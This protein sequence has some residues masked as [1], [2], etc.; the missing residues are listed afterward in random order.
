MALVGLA[1]VGS[2]QGWLQHAGDP[3]H[4][5]ISKN[6]VQSL[7]RVLWS[8]KVDLAPVYSGS[9]LLMHYGS[10]LISLN[11][12]V[13]IPVKT[14]PSDGFKVEGRRAGTGDL[15]W[16][17][18][19]DYS[20]PPHGW[21]PTCGPAIG[22]DNAVYVPA[23][24]GTILRRSNVDARVS[25]VQRLSFYGLGLYNTNKAAF[26][27]A[28][29]I[30]T[31]ITV[32]SKGNLFFGF[33]VLAGNPA[34]LTGGL[35]KIS[36]GGQGTWV[37]AAQ[38]SGDPVA[39]RPAMSCAP[40]LSNDE[41][42]VYIGARGGSSR[43]GYL[44][45]INAE[46]MQP[47]RSVR[48]KVPGSATNEDAYILDDSTSTPSVGPDGDVYY[49]AWFFNNYRGYMMHFDA[50]LSVEKTPGAFGWDNTPS[51]VPLSMVPSYTGPSPYLLLSKYNNY[52]G[53]TGEG[54]NMMAIL[55]PNIEF[56]D[57]F[58]DAM[59]MNEVW[60][61]LAPT[62]D[63]RGGFIEWC[64][65]TCA[66]DPFTRTAVVNSEDG[67]VYRWNLVKNTLTE[68]V[69]LTAGLGEAYTSTVIGPD[70]LSIAM[71]NATMFMIWDGI[72][73]KEIVLP[74]SIH[75]GETIDGLIRLSGKATGPGTRIGLNVTRNGNPSSLLTVPDNITVAAGATEK[76][77]R[78]TAGVVTSEVLLTLTAN[79]YGQS[80]AKQI[81]LRPVGIRSLSSEKS[82]LY[83]PGV[84]AAGESTTG[85]VKLTG[86]LAL[87]AT[88]D[89]ST[90]HPAL[91]VSPAQLSIASGASSG[92][93]TISTIGPVTGVSTG[94]VVAKLGSQ[95]TQLPIEIRP[96]STLVGFG[97]GRNSGF[98]S[99]LIRSTLTLNSPAPA[100][101]IS[102]SVNP[103]AGLLAPNAVLIPAGSSEANFALG[104]GPSGASA[105]T[106]TI[107][108]SQGAVQM[109]QSVV[110]KPIF[111]T[112][113]VI[114][115]SE[116]IGGVSTVGFVSVSAPAGSAFDLTVAL[117]V[118][119]GPVSVPATVTIPDGATG[120]QF[121]VVTDEVTSTTTR[122]IT[123]SRNG[124][125]ASASVKLTTP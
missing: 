36:P 117:S 82:Y 68:S 17:L 20:L 90:D 121:N 105:I 67:K 91:Q 3:Q 76:G 72:T 42:I 83:V 15:V 75:S 9:A 102:I 10:P 22:P 99:Q 39:D 5:N 94:N 113:L 18:Y 73:A 49:G 123:A 57:P 35:A 115:P 101:G 8:T 100:G 19:T 119:T 93:F 34:N 46:T 25:D 104:L 58:S 66:I 47:I 11:S 6:P 24:G 61:K 64:V 112:S 103:G 13:V 59:V 32:D 28:V 27:S 51:I 30:C 108:V 48:L 37:A 33:R 29:K 106:R 118:P 78:A 89:L 14:G 43:P 50:S 81:T 45:A 79:R 110:V 1:S 69:R 2:S 60:T 124:S 54:N 40:A 70:G 111:V 97:L 55:D 96:Q 114:D 116:V 109:A 4:T 87:G 23:A 98:E 84:A 85:T 71:S 77:F 80:I 26:D 38:F 31:P 62:P 53:T 65:N 41:S 107:T 86:N 12:T 92:T 74:D 44:C 63:P 21:T 16:T 56:Q 7:R 88:I 120:L 122:T 125:S 95:T 52:L